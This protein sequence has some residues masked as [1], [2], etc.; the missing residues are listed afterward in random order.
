MSDA[1]IAKVCDMARVLCREY[2]GGRCRYYDEDDE[3]GGDF[4]CSL[5]D[6]CPKARMLDAHPSIVV[7]QESSCGKTFTPFRSDAKF[8]SVA[9]RMASHRGGR[10][11]GLR[12]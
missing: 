9:C 6:S 4:P 5:P 8:C 12:R 1:T 11:R 2:R 7:C 3:F 10:R